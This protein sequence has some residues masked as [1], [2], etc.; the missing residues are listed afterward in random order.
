MKSKTISSKIKIIGILYII[1]MTVII[2][3]TIYLNN[4]NKKDALLI[5]IAGKQRML[6]QKIS[7][8]IFYLHHN[9]NTSSIAELDNATIEFIYNLNSLKNG[10]DFIG[11]F[12]P[13]TDKIK[14]Q[15]SKI[16]I[17][18]NTF[19]NNIND[20]KKDISSSH[21]AKNKHAIRTIVDSVYQTN[22]NLLNEVD[23]LVSMYTIYTEKK[24]EYLK[25]IQYFF[26][27]FIIVLLAYSFYQLKAMEENVKRFFKISKNY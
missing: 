8:N 16:E 2:I 10:N 6:T 24:T 5:N 7:K 14:N 27:L 20:F 1:L 9:Y 13:P 17:L 21:K 22:N 15:I 12:K 3:T 19:F 26:A 23:K 18:W 25:Y 4:K 11:I